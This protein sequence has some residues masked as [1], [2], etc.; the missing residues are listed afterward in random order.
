MLVA[1]KPAQHGIKSPDRSIYEDGTG[2]N[3]GFYS[4]GAYVGA[5]IKES[6]D[7]LFADGIVR[8]AQEVYFETLLKRFHKL[9]DQLSRK[10]PQ[11]VIDGLSSSHPSFMTSSREDL[12]SWRWRL[13]NT[14]PQP[15]QLAIMDKGTV[16]KILRLILTNNGALGG[17]T[18]ISSRLSRWIWGL[19]AK[20]PD[21]GELTSEEVGLI[22]E[23]GKRAVWLGVEMR[24]VD[25]RELYREKNCG[26]D[27]EEENV[28]VVS[29]IDDRND[30]DSETATDG[31]RII[32]PV[33]PS[34]EEASTNGVNVGDP[35]TEENAFVTPPIVYNTRGEDI[36]AQQANSRANAPINEVEEGETGED[37]EDQARIAA[38]K[39]RLLAGLSN[40]NNKGTLDA[41]A[42]SDVEAE[43]PQKTD[44]KSDLDN[45]KIT[46][47][48]IITIAGE[49]YGQRDLL[50]F[51]EEW[52]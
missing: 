39:Q 14:D 15:A 7:S 43:A 45:A 51:R 40:E 11:M 46:V 48:M 21:S 36:Q 23:L 26:D 31:V 44:H 9:H 22:R 47:D 20:V 16:F 3:R 35:A 28:V 38:M 50:E 12:R 19:L 49:V 24:G 1:P 2:D 30:A 33:M 41:V 4:E 52:E 42:M 29:D 17:K 25:I 18:L 13:F 8:G 37:E 34:T 27:N 5:S 6:S 32:G 10:P